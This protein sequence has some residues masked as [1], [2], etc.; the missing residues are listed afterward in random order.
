MYYLRGFL[1]ACQWLSFGM[2]V[3]LA[4]AAL[5]LTGAAFLG[6]LTL[7]GFLVG[8]SLGQLFTD[9]VLANVAGAVA[10]VLSL[11]AGIGC[12]YSFSPAYGLIEDEGVNSKL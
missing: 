11:L 6:M 8:S 9:G 7:C 4:I 5:S 12:L 3:L 10:A 2:I 1:K